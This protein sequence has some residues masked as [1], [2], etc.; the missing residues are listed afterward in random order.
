MPALPTW[1]PRVALKFMRSANQGEE[2]R[3]FIANEWNA[4]KRYTRLKCGSGA[5][6][7]GR[8]KQLCTGRKFWVCLTQKDRT[9]PCYILAS[10]SIQSFTCAY[11]YTSC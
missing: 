11:M 3:Y 10:L 2:H 5:G 7:C 6:A 9:I 1:E 8:R 4:T